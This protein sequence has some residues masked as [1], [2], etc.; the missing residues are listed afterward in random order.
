MFAFNVRKNVSA[1]AIVIQF[2]QV[3]IISVPPFVVSVHFNNAI[4][5]VYS[6]LGCV[7]HKKIKPQTSNGGR[8]A[9]QRMRL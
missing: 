5:F 7:F 6:G 4:I 2:V 9:K 8:S 3:K 1:L